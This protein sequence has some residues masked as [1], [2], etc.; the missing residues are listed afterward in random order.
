MKTLLSCA[1]VALFA[2]VSVPAMAAGNAQQ[3]KMKSCNSQA[4]GKKGDERKT[5]MK[6]CL[7]ADKAGKGENKMATC[8][9]K[10]KGMKGDERKKF[11]SDC[12]KGSA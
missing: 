11:M 4:A 7:S 12:M 5:F 3:D 10:S 6:D 9:T 2:A 8:N 1:L